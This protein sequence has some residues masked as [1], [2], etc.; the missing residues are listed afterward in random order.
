[1]PS[2]S[3][4]LIGPAIMGAGSLT[5]GLL[6]SNAAVTAAGIQANAATTAANEQ[7]QAAQLATSTQQGIFNTTQSNL[8][9]YFTAGQSALGNLANIF[10]FAGPGGTGGSGVP[11]QQALMSALQNYP[12]YQFGLN[13]GVQALDRS[14]ASTGTLLS[15][16]QLK[17]AQ[18]YGQQYAQQNAW[19]PYLSGLT[20]VANLGENAA[21]TTG[22]IGAA[23]G[24]GLSN[25]IIGGTNA[26]AQSQLAAAQ[27]SAAGIVGSTNAI[28][29]NLS[30]GLNN[31]VLGYY[32]QNGL[33]NNSNNLLNVNANNLGQTTWSNGPSS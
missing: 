24:T 19:Q 20:G 25:S 16:G 2:F 26:A 4:A 22:Q 28:T 13:Q 11:N 12:G 23:T 15:G 6:G 3:A 18:Q 9:P 21:A 31:A 1:M 27:A 5:S 10:G 32:L 30:S 8:S 17:A 33:N 14:A 7:L 29:G